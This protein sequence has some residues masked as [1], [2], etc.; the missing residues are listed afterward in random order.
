MTIDF[1]LVKSERLAKYHNLLNFDCGDPDINEFIV[2]DSYG[3]QEK[4]I[5]T[6]TVFIYNEEIIGFCSIAA[7]SIKL[8][9]NEEKVHSIDDKPVR[10][11]PAV[12]IARIGRDKKYK[13]MSVGSNIL[14]WAIGH[15]LVCS[16]LMAIRFITVDSYPHRMQ[17]Y[18]KLGFV[19]NEHKTYKDRIQNVSMRYDLFNAMS[20]K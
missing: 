4:K 2:N 16:D 13:E 19:K 18:E 8:S 3:Y 10:E 20:Q 15:I 12:K 1:S 17:Y 5:A 7:D 6:T 9:E 11:F 14:K